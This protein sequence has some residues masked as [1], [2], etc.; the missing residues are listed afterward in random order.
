MEDKKAIELA[1]NDFACTETLHLVD[2]QAD[3]NWQRLQKLLNE[4]NESHE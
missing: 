3:L 2:Q 4:N 1:V